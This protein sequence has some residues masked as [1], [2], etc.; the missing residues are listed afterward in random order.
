MLEPKF[1]N[2]LTG[3]KAKTKHGYEYIVLKT[4]TPE[5]IKEEY[6]QIVEEQ[7]K[8]MKENKPIIKF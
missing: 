4:N 6:L 3:K 2:Y 8:L 5:D 7:D 1:F